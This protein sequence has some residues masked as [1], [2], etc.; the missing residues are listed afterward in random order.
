MDSDGTYSMGGELRWNSGIP[1]VGATVELW[2]HFMGSKKH[3]GQN[4]GW[5][6]V[7]SAEIKC[8]NELKLKNVRWNLYV[9]LRSQSVFDAFFHL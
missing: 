3:A 5:R 1:V 9:Q 6:V 8:E 2:Q 7:S 4:N